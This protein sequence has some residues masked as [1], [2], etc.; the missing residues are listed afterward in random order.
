[1]GNGESTKLIPKH[2]A[3]TI[4][5][6]QVPS[7]KAI[8]NSQFPIILLV[9]LGCHPQVGLDFLITLGKFLLEDF[10]IF[11]GG[12]NHTVTAIRPVNWGCHTV[13]I[14]ELQLVNHPQNFIKVTT[15]AGGVGKSQPQ[16]LLRVDDEDRTYC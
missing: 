7:T 3:R 5:L 2:N 11:E 4:A 9:G 8:P 13:V 12:D 14:G 6:P 16:F 1:M 15:R 10:W